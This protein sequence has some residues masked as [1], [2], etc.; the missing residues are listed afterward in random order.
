MDLG[1]NT[2]SKEER[3]YSKKDIGRLLENGH[4]SST[5]I[6]R[7]CCLRENGEKQS[8]IMVSVPKKFFKRAVK[9]NLLK[10]RI[11]ESYRLQKGILSSPADILFTY[12]SKE[13][14]EY[15][16]IYETVGKIL[17]RIEASNGQRENQ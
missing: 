7:Y 4:F 16:R 11:R 15:A 17:K 14:A 9:R 10:R 12:T 3:L 1:A 6:I 8:R 2:L 5:D 13:V